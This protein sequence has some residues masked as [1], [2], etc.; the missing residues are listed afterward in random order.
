LQTCINETNVV[1]LDR[2]RELGLKTIDAERGELENL[3]SEDKIGPT[4]YLGLQEQ[5]DWNELAVL[6]DV[7]RQIEE[8]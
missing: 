1:A 5:L 2:L 8:I 7:D 6:P 3:R 4:T